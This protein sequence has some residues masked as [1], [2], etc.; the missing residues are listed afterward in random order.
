[1]PAWRAQGQFHLLL[2]LQAT[3]SVDTVETSVFYVLIDQELSKLF[4]FAVGAAHVLLTD[5]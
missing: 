4:R 3:S 5:I 1:M 2:I